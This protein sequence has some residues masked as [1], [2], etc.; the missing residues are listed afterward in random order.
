MYAARRW[1]PQKGRQTAERHE[2]SVFGERY[3]PSAGP[4]HKFGRPIR[5]P[6][7][8]AIF[9]DI[10]R[11]QILWVVFFTWSFVLLSMAWPGSQYIFL[12]KCFKLF[13][14]KASTN[15]VFGTHGEGLG[16]LV[17]FLNVQFRDQCHFLPLCVLY[18]YIYKSLFGL[19]S[20]HNIPSADYSSLN[21]FQ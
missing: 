4:F 6:L 1:C 2:S 10:N 11:N 19:E 9:L 15:G 18:I 14:S 3:E 12:L 8:L 21:G 7:T 17:M 5:F 20:V 16:R 13:F